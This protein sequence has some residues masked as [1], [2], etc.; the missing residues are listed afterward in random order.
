[1]KASWGQI[2]GTGSRLL[3]EIQGVLGKG[4]PGD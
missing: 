4:S 1:M 2:L 3:G